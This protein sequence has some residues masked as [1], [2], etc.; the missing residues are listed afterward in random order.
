MNNSIYCSK[1]EI[2]FIPNKSNTGCFIGIDYCIVVSDSN[3]LI[4]VNCDKGFYLSNNQCLEGNIPNCLEYDQDESTPLTPCKKCQNGF[5]LSTND[6]KCH[7]GNVQGCL[8]HP[9]DEPER[10]SSCDNNLYLMSLSRDY[11]YS[12]GNSFVCS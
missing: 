5:F 1:C 7:K 12:I 9:N 2:G 4:C 6:K 10:C 11:C 3:S 8:I